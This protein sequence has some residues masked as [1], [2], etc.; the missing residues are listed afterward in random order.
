MLTMAEAKSAWKNQTPV[1]YTSPLAIKPIKCSIRSIKF[2]I[3]DGKELTELELRQSK[4]SIITTG[5]MY[6]SIE[7]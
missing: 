3:E 2:V 5:P 7:P 4:N 1:Y 6:V